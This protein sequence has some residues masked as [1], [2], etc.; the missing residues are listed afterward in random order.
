MQNPQFRQKCHLWFCTHPTILNNFFFC[1]VCDLQCEA[2]QATRVLFYQLFHEPQKLLNIGGGCAV[3]TVPLAE[4][5]HHW[6]LI[7]VSIKNS[8]HLKKIR[9]KP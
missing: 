1:S 2:G 5:S 3:S 4:T 7:T 8:W 9:E 6:N